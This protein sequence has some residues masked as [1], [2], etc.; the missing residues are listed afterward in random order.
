MCEG[1]GGR[2][3]HLLTLGRG[4]EAADNSGGIRQIDSAS[5]ILSAHYY[6]KLVGG[7]DQ[8][9]YVWLLIRRIPRPCSLPSP[10]IAFSHIYVPPHLPYSSLPIQMLSSFP[11]PMLHLALCF[12]Y[13]TYLCIPPFSSFSISISHRFLFL[14]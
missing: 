7:R 10:P 3:S 12:A 2:A 13:L 9:C 5:Q 14:S 11:L 6:L 1:G 4:E 8:A